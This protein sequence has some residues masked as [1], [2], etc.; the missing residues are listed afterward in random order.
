MIRRMY[1]QEALQN[2]YPF[3]MG[4]VIFWSETKIPTEESP[5]QWHALDRVP[6]DWRRL[7]LQL[8]SGCKTEA[9]KSFIFEFQ[10][11]SVISMFFC[12][13]VLLVF[14]LIKWKRV[15]A[16]WRTHLAGH[17]LWTRQM[18]KWLFFWCPVNSRGSPQDESPFKFFYTSSEHKSLSH[19]HKRLRTNRKFW[20]SHHISVQ[21]TPVTKGNSSHH[22][23][24]Q[25]PQVTPGTTGNTSHHR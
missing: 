13:V 14:K 21:V 2:V 8:P 9:V 12:A 1:K 7:R 20:L 4:N 5:L 23:W 16:E 11:M 24:H 3:V 6:T 19:N 17:R 25:A 22:R 18:D 10:F 15:T